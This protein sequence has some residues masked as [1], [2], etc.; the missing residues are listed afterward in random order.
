[1]GDR[2]LVEPHFLEKFFA[3]KCATSDGMVRTHPRDMRDFKAFEMPPKSIQTMPKST[4]R[5]REYVQ[6]QNRRIQMGRRSG[7]AAG[8]GCLRCG[9]IGGISTGRNGKPKPTNG[10]G[11]KPTTSA[12]PSAGTRHT[13]GRTDP[14]GGCADTQNRRWSAGSARHPADGTENG[15][16]G[17]AS[18]SLGPTVG[19][20]SAIGTELTL[21]CPERSR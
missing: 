11:A 7:L 1:M 4:E 17:F 3:H 8:L 21:C 13:C 18:R 10:R 19:T 15:T 14:P 2:N 5:A 16:R 20:P 12:A 9:S 6:K